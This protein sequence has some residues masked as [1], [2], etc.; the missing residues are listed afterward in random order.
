LQGGQLFFPCKAKI[1]ACLF[2]RNILE[3]DEMSECAAQRRIVWVNAFWLKFD[4]FFSVKI[5][6]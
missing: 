5:E 2:N 4:S 6:K 1:F 3:A